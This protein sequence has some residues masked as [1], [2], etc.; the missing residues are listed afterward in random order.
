MSEK[1]TG[2]SLLFPSKKTEEELFI[3]YT[4]SLYHPALGYKMFDVKNDKITPTETAKKL[5]PAFIKKIEGKR[6]FKERMKFLKSK[7]FTVEEKKGEESEMLELEEEGKRGKETEK[8][9]ESLG[10]KETESNLSTEKV[11]YEKDDFA[12]NETYDES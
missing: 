9:I 6:G 7:G 2:K 5:H 4:G 12:M 8:G 11:L 10:G 3:D 1:E